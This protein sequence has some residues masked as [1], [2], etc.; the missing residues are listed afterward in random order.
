M[1]YFVYLA[2]CSDHSL[3]TGCCTDTASREK[4]HNT[5]KG[6]QYTK[7]RRP[8]NIIY[9]EKYDNLTDARKREAQIKRWTRVKKEKR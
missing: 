8:V 4:R 3:Y 6:A 7:Q 5:G 1:K 9:I 2:R